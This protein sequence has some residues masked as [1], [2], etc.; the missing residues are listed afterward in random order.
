MSK[1]IY[2]SQ[3]QL[4]R[5]PEFF[6]DENW[7]KARLHDRNTRIVPVWKNLSLILDHESPSAITFSGDHARGLLEMAGEIALLGM[8]GPDAGDDNA[9]A[10]FAVD[11]SEHELPSLAAMMGRAE[12]TDLRQ[13]GVLMDSHE[14]S[15]LAHARGLMFWHYNNRFCSNCGSTSVSA[16]GGRMRRCSNPECAREHFP[17]TDPA[18]IMLVIRPGPDGGACLMGRGHNFRE[19][20]YSSLAGFVDQGESLEQAVAREVFEETGIS[21]EDVQ[22]RASQPWPFPSSLMLG[23]RT[24]ATSTKI[25]IDHKELA[26]ARWFPRSVVANAATSGLKLPREDSIASWLIKDWLTEG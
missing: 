24:R 5:A 12:F 14:G 6:S 25:N 9:S 10:Y 13:V 21:V 3:S 7:L 17:R 22:Y 4:F 2:Y 23:F 18:V 8:D 26:D 11:V 15:M 20:M 1:A 19:G 16:Q